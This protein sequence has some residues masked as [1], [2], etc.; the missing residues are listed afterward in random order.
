M[1]EY[2]N[3]VYRKCLQNALG[4]KTLFE[5]TCKQTI[6]VNVISAIIKLFISE[7]SATLVD[8]FESPKDLDDPTNAL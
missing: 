7:N 4:A 8:K 1:E 3:S 5:E 2:C 6:D